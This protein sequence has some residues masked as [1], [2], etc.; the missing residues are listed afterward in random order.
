M[1]VDHYECDECGRR[2]RRI[3]VHTGDVLGDDRE[4]H[5][6]ST[7]CMDERFSEADEQV[8]YWIT[9]QDLRDGA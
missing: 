9:G 1:K 2:V 4:L 6:C 8:T 3:T 7:R 5:F